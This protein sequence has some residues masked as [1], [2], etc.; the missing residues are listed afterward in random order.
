MRFFLLTPILLIA[1]IAAVAEPTCNPDDTLAL[2]ETHNRVRRETNLPEFVLDETLTRYAYERAV[3][4]AQQG[5]LSHAGYDL[6]APWAWGG[7]NF[8]S[9]NYPEN[10]RIDSMM[11]AWLKSHG[12]LSNILSPHFTHIGIACVE[13][14]NDY[15]YCAVEFG[16][17]AY[18]LK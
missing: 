12:H 8:G 15:F 18:V 1:L 10:Q 3:L 14:K 11:N 2:L 16:G 6:P 17:P 7:E 13:T 9:S 4:Q 5:Y